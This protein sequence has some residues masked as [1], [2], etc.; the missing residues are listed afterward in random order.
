VKLGLADQIRS[1]PDDDDGGL[2]RY[3]GEILTKILDGDAGLAGET[4][5]REV[6][7]VKLLKS[8]IDNARTQRTVVTA[9]NP[10]GK[11]IRA[12]ERLH[13]MYKTRAQLLGVARSVAEST[14][15]SADVLRMLIDQAS[16]KLA[17]GGSAS[18]RAFL[19]GLP[20]RFTAADYLSTNEL[21]RIVSL[22]QVYNRLLAFEISRRFPDKDSR[23]SQ[24][25]ANTQTKRTATPQLDEPH[26]IRQLQHGERTTLE[27]WMLFAP[28]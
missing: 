15:S 4:H 10:E 9:N 19:A 28:S 11:Y 2:R 22:Q 1:F 23:A 17:G 6:A 7:Y 27:L 3:V 24:V 13:D 5:W 18:E 21:K 20:Y 25:I 8:A 12:S 14:P 16:A 26:L